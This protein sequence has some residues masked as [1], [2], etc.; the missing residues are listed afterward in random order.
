MQIKKQLKNEC[1]VHKIQIKKSG[2]V[3]IFVS[4]R[5][6]SKKQIN[7]NTDEDLRV[8]INGLEFREIPPAKNKQLFN[9]PASFNGSK[10]KGLKKSTVFPI[11]SNKQDLHYIEIW[12]DQKPWLEQVQFVVKSGIQVIQK[13][14]LKKYEH[15]LDASKLPKSYFDRD[16]N[17]YDK[18]IIKAVNHWNEYFTKQ[19]YSPSELL[20]PNLVKA[21][22]VRESQMGYLLSKDSFDLMQIGNPADK[23]LAHM[24]PDHGYETRANEFIPKG[25]RKTELQ[26][27]QGFEHMSYSYPQDKKGPNV[28]TAEDSIFWGVRWLFHK[29]QYM[30]Q[31]SKKP[32]ERKWR[33]WKQAVVKYNSQ[34]KDKFYQQDIYTLFETGV[35]YQ[36]DIDTGEIIK[37][38]LWKK[39]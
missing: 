36:R 23:T 1:F 20:D 15:K 19:K 9:I 29:A 3:A 2:L 37:Y 12:A 6:K 34:I 10:L 16:Y 11:K 31:I 22:I 5:C 38:H 13:Y 14:N 33:T 18:E 8:E 4:A 24:R 30:P 21:M 28:N 25:L 7:S 17:R 26:K 32:L 27:K 39:L 35:Y